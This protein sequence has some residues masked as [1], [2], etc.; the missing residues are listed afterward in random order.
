MSQALLPDDNFIFDL[1]IVV[2]GSDAGAMAS[3]PDAPELRD[4][5]GHVHMGLLFTLIDAASGRVALRAAAPRFVATSQISL[6]SR[7]P[8]ARGPIEARA[9]PLRSGRASMAIGAEI[10]AGPPRDAELIGEGIATFSFIGDAPTPGGGALRSAAG[11]IGTD[12]E[13]MQL[14]NRESGLPAP[15]L[16]AIGLRLVDPAAGVA[17]IALTP[18]VQNH[19]NALQGGIIA[20][21]A[22]VAAEQCGRA[23]GAELL[24]DL[25]VQYLSL[26]RKG[27]FTSRARV[28]RERR[29]ATAVRVE[30]LDRGAGDRI[31][32]IATAELGM[33]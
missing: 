27:P 9:V 32:A 30:I 16:E 19:L 23:A 24:L 14:G 15:F 3:L 4:D 10:W 6:Q 12:D 20:S 1:R 33:A 28:V 21:L 8:A 5:R 26:G 13:P 7:A 17:E 18:Y 11:L 31:I 2:G 25:A 22:Q 29:E